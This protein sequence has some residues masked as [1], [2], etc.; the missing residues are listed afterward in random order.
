[1]EF[2]VTRTSKPMELESARI[3]TMGD[4]L[5]F[6]KKVA[7]GWPVLVNMISDTNCQLK[8]FDD[9]NQLKGARDRYPMMFPSR[10]TMIDEEE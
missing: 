5:D 6:I 1:M 9:R 8:V 4:L 2:L 10:I 3:E 7:H